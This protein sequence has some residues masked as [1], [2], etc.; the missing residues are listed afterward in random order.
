MAW[1]MS[2]E[3]GE[4]GR[5]MVA[6]NQLAKRPNFVLTLT[7]SHEVISGMRISHQICILEELF[8]QQSQYRLE[9]SGWRQK[10]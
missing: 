10:N 7:G 3:A 6:L 5:F 1:L 4:R 2:K 9:R 8:Q